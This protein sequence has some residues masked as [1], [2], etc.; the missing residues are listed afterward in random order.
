[1]KNTIYMLSLLVFSTTILQCEKEEQESLQVD[2]VQTIHGGCNGLSPDEI[3]LPRNE[4]KDTLQL[5]MK[6]DTL[7]VYAGINYICCAPFETD[8]S[9]SGDSLLF[10]IKDTCHVAVDNCYCRCMCYYTFTFLFT[11]FKKGQYYLR[12]TIIDPRQD[13]PYI[14]REGMLNLD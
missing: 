3:V 4:E 2:H 1:M 10:L 9:Q 8:F 12:I 11:G 14:F 7:N 6:N 5:N 13:E